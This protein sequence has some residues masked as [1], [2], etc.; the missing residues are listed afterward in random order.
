MTAS[1]M[2]PTLRRAGWLVLVGL[3]VEA[4]TLLAP[5]SPKSFFAFLVGGGLILVGSVVFL[6]RLARQGGTAG[7]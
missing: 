2:L 7:A 1:S 3:V 4:I 6:W 5:P